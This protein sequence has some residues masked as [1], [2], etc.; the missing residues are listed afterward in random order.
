MVTTDYLRRGDQ[1]DV[2]LRNHGHQVRYSPAQRTRSHA[3]AMSLLAGVDGAI[4]ASES[5]TAD[6]LAAAT[7]LKVVARSGVG[8][9]SVD[10]AAATARGI[11]VCNAPGVNHHSVAEHTVALMLA[12]ARRLVPTVEMVRAGGWPRDAGVELRGATLSV[13]G[14][15]PSGRAVAEL[16][17]AFGMNVLVSTRYPAEV[18]EGVQFVGRHQAIEQA[19]YLTLHMRFDPSVGCVITEQELSAMKPTAVLINTARGALVDED[20]LAAALAQRRI[21][22]AALDVLRREPLPAESPLHRL[23]NVVIT[24]HL[25]GQT[26]QARLRAGLVAAQAVIDVLAGREPEYPVDRP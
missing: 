18:A 8:Y 13:L 25:A 7:T 10:V 26:E 22:G 20:A 19:D 1:V 6:M 11:R 12:M 5:I 9:D 16:G 3:E 15:G 21:G 4:V 17:K 24:S 23:D 2:L 14:Y